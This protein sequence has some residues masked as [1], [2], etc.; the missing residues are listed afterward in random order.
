MDVKT[1]M[2]KHHAVA[3]VKQ[4]QMFGIQD[5]INYLV[6]L[7]KTVQPN[8]KEKENVYKFISEKMEL[9]ERKKSHIY[10]KHWIVKTLQCYRSNVM[11]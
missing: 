4:G 11:F 1:V 3:R 7:F 5:V 6:N 2:K 10:L 8:T 9:R